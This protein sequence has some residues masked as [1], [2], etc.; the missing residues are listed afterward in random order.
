MGAINWGGF[1]GAQKDTP[2][3]LAMFA[4]AFEHLEIGGYEQLARV[5][6]RAG[7]EESAGVAGRILPEERAAAEKLFAAFP[8]ALDASLEAVLT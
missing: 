8:A 5:A 6:Q 1:F 2:A 7:D 4:Y 3:K